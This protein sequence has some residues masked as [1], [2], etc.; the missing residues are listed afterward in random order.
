MIVDSLE[1]E[2]DSE[3]SSEDITM[4]LYHT[5]E[6]EALNDFKARTKASK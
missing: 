5:A 2:S 4:S 1:K 3:E 6:E